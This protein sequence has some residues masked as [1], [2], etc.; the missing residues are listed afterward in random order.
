MKKSIFGC[1]LKPPSKEIA[2]PIR[3]AIDASNIYL[4]F[5]KV[6]NTYMDSQYYNILVKKPSISE[7]VYIHPSANIHASAKVELFFNNP[8]L[9]LM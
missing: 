2:L 7:N 4:S 6:Q 3:S 5:N 1:K 8:R 9:D